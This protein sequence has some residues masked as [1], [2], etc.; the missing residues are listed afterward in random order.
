MA[1]DSEK[2]GPLNLCAIFGIVTGRSLWINTNE[3]NIATA[4][5]SPKGAEISFLLAI[6]SSLP[7]SQ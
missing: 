5:A 7:S 1:R 4:I 3:V 2:E 6:A